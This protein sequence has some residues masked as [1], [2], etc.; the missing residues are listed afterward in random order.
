MYKKGSA[1]QINGFDAW[2]N[3]NILSDRI[4]NLHSTTILGHL[5]YSFLNHWQFY[6]FY[7]KH[8]RFTAKKFRSV[9]RHWS[10]PVWL[11]IMWDW[12]NL[13]WLM[14]K[15]M[16]KVISVVLHSLCYNISLIALVSHAEIPVCCK[17]IFIFTSEGFSEI[18]S[19]LWRMQLEKYWAIKPRVRIV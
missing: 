13:A 14:F 7:A 4:F 5:H 17:E 9:P 18:L 19:I 1:A 8:S 6:H 3:D 10:C 2:I 16:W 15:Q 12:S 11:R